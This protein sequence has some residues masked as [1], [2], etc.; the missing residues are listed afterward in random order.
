MTNRLFIFLGL[1]GLFPWILWQQ[2]WPN[3][4]ITQLD[5]CPLA[6]CDF[7]R[8]Y[9]PQAEAL[10]S[11]PLTLVHGWF[12]PPLLAIV[13]LPLIWSGH[14]VLSWLIVLGASVVALS[15]VALKPENRR[16]LQLVMTVLFV[17][18]SLSVLH[19]LKW[20]Q[21]SLPLLVLCILGLLRGGISGGGLLGLATAIKGY[22]FVYLIHPLL[23][24]KTKPIVGAVAAFLIV[25][26]LIP[27]AVMGVAET[28]IMYQNMT[29]SG[30]AVAMIVA[31]SGGQNLQA[32]LQRWFVD[33]SHVGLIPTTE[34]PQALVF[35][36][37]L[38]VKHAI[39]LIF[40]GGLTWLTLKICS[41]KV[42]PP[43]RL[44]STVLIL[45][46]VGL[47]LPPGWHHY[48]AFLPFAQLQLLQKNQKRT[49]TTSLIGASI[50]LERIPIFLL[51]LVDIGY[52]LASAYGTTTIATLLCWVAWAKHIEK[53]KNQSE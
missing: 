34:P 18:S 46:Y 29:K 50:V 37:P 33:G 47:M 43:S 24:K 16:P 31:E 30:Q 13:L 39:W 27:F 32:T 48:Y 40:A 15:W 28:L 21:V 25:G 9:L 1:M 19:G 7:Q 38:M 5:H 11:K 20:G 22:P 4:V 23:R 36:L 17:T 14:A 44:E 26:V 6:F 2:G 42:N 12:Y 53:N 41:Q 3:I 35:P 10:L 8:H 45:C 52:P 51:G 49:L